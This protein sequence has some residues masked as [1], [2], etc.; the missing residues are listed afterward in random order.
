MSLKSKIQK[1]FENKCVFMTGGTGLV[2]S[3]LI[4]KFFRSCPEVGN[5]YVLIREK[6]N[7]SHQERIEEI[8][9]QPIFDNIKKHNPTILRKLV[10]INGDLEKPN[11]GMNVEDW[12]H[13]IKEVN[14][15]LHVG[16][17]V[18][19]SSPLSLA[20][21]SNVVGTMEITRLAKQA[22][23]LEAFV[24]VSSTYAHCYIDV[25]EEIFYTS[26][27]TSE[28]L[29]L[30]MNEVGVEKFDQMSSIFLDKFPNAY[31]YSKYLTE[32]FLRRNAEGL[33]LA[34][35]RPSI[36]CT[37]LNEP[38]PGWGNHF[39]S[40][41]NF[42]TGFAT[43]L[44]HVLMSKPN[45]ILDIVPADVVVNHI[46]A[47]T[48]ELGS[49]RNS[50]NNCT[51]IYNCGTSCENPLTMQRFEELLDKYEAVFPTNKKFWHRFVC[52]STSR[53]IRYLFYLIQFL[54]MYLLDF[55]SLILKKP[56]IYCKIYKKSHYLMDLTA[57]FTK[58]SWVFKTHNRKRLWEKLED[59]DKKIFNF[60]I[61][62]M[63]WELLMSNS[64]KGIRYY[65]L[66]EDPKTMPK[67][68]IKRH[69]LRILHYFLFFTPGIIV[70]LAL[71]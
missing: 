63:D 32:D 36:V 10:A 57:Y 62:H 35:L 17:A 64:V 70:L 29:F 58:K 22:K 34:I 9:S 54:Q 46:I 7:V 59:A 2:G 39:H 45:C 21:K 13:L 33:P 24:Y 8:C 65:F 40:Y 68:Q 31:T 60:D 14:C 28:T 53:S 49:T 61:S 69:S 48:W 15:I 16:A 71:Y 67:A 41:S 66:K 23:N 30:L 19:F 50:M 38:F 1:Y 26:S 52:V 3:L 4:E 43:G 6:K 25:V 20:F 27:I 55:V 56:Q 44:V 51:L 5:I 47:V 12:D 11:L 18:K 42:V 37:T